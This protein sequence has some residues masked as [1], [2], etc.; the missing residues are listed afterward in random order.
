MGE[1]IKFIA[2]PAELLWIEKDPIEFRIDSFNWR[3]HLGTFDLLAFY[4][5]KESDFYGAYSLSL[6]VRTGA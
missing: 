2:F 4:W 1:C 6:Y 3:K 5:S